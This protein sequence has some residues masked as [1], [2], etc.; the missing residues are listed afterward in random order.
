MPHVGALVTIET[1]FT[2]SGVATDPT[3]ASCLFR[4]PNGSK[5][6]V[7]ATRS[8][9]GV[10]YATVVPDSAGDWYYRMV[11]VMSAGNAVDEGYFNVSLSRFV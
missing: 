5:F 10:Y 11:G 2:V 4:M 3:S 9:T 1:T 8:A 6:N 7:S